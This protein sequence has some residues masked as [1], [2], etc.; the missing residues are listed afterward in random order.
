MQKSR[1]KWL[2]DGDSNTRFFHRAVLAH[3]AKNLISY[4]R[5]EGG[6]RVDDVYQVKEMIV[7]YY[8]N[9][10][11]SESGCISPFSVERIQELHPFRCNSDMATQLSSIPTEE[12]II[13]TVFSMPRN[14]APGPDGFTAEFFWDSWPVVKDSVV[15]AVQEFFRTRHLLKRFNATAI[16]LIPKVSGADQ[17]SMFRPVSCCTTVYKLI[18]RLISSRLKLFIPQAVQGNQVGFIKGHLLCENVL[19]A[20]EL[21]ENFHVE[22]EVTRGC[23]QIDLTKAY[24][25]VNW[26]FL[27]NILQALEL[28][29][30]FINWI[31]VCISSPSYSVAFNGELIGYFQGKKGIRQGDPMS[32]HL[33]VLVMDILARSL[34]KGAAHGVF[35]PHPKC[36]A[37]LVTHLSFADDVLV[38]FDGSAN[39]L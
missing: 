23:L 16:T 24:D 6:S 36:T 38:F 13:R 7:E 25:N 17:L 12:E 28:P 39:S 18:T 33:F 29:L 31:K 1:I 32:S 10:L 34:D 4:L 21:V 8:S 26:A 15:A 14:K 30:V 3:Q 37:P 22:G 20:S 27:L 11:G 19:L 2:R 35:R 9:L 5:D